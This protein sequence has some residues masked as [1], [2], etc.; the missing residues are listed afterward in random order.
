ML[1]AFAAP[2]DETFRCSGKLINAGMAMADVQA[3]CGEPTS[4]VVEE[5]PQR[6]R[7]AGG[8]TQVV[9]TVTV[10]VWT[11][12]RGSSSFPAVLRFEGGKLVSVELVRP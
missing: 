11:Y 9:G 2:A 8:T 3:K 6:A 12:D 4:R 1:A 5:V 7:R 10:D